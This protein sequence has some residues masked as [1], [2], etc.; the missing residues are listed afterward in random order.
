VVGALGCGGSSSSNSGFGNPDAGSDVPVLG[1]GDGS[2]GDGS[3]TLGDGQPG[4]DSGPQQIAEVFGESPDTLYRL[5]PMTKAVTVVGPFQGCS[6]VIDI[7][8][9]KDSNMYGTT[10]SGLYKI[11]RNNATCTM[12]ASGNYPN[13]LSFVP[14]GTLD[15]NVEALV[16]Y[17]GSM[18][19]RIDPT[20][21][22]ITNVGSIGG[23]Y[24]SSGDIVSVKG[25]STYL[26]VKGANC[27]TDC[28]LEVDPKTGSLIKD[29][30]DVAH[31][32][33]FGLAFWAGAVYGFDN[34]GQ[35]FEVDFTNGMMTTKLI[36]VPN[37]PANLQ[38]WGA[39]STTSAPPTPVTH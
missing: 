37:P 14:A 27:A 3:P 2:N 13:S 10:F 29:W 22:A 17:V 24:S 19:I 33:V 4:G 8:L 5:D 20:T 26:T 6:Q 39:G 18:Y 31:V 15:P 30:G 9:D 25:G 38:F 34:G 1:G 16:G 28:L 12:I 36:P 21:G 11:D 32:D 35:L 23:G 7:A